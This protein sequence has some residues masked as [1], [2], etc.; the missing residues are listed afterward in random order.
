MSGKLLIMEG[1]LRNSQGMYTRAISSYLKALEYEE[2]VPY[3]EFGL[4]SVYFAMGEEKAALDRFAKAG[5]LLET[6]PLEANHELRYRILYNTG[7]VLLSEGDFSGAADSFREALK[8]DGG[9]K[10]AKRNL[11]LS[12]RSLDRENASSGGK[13]GGEGENESMIALL[14][15]V[16]QTEYNQWKS[17]EWQEENIIGPD[18]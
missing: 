16:R 18:Y 10:D 17:R 11:E 9:K 1:N 15:Y 6:L 5:T 8:V 4:G 12:I 7:V 14:E 3:S 2:A 13:H